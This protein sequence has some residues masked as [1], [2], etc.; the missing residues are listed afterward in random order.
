MVIIYS[1]SIQGFPNYL[2]I[3]AGGTIISEKPIQHYTATFL[4]LK[5]YATTQFDMIIAEDIGLYKFD[6]LSQRG[7]GKIKDAVEIVHK[8]YPDKPK[9]DLHKIQRRQKNQVSLEKCQGNWL[10]LCRVS[11]HAHAD[12]QTLSR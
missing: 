1:K 10:F 5:G 6:I 8:N 2:G 12:N 4:P 9:I 11:C 7:L 3:H